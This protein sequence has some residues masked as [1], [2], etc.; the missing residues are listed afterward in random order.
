MLGMTGYKKIHPKKIPH[1]KKQLYTIYPVY[2]LSVC[3]INAKHSMRDFNELYTRLP[4]SRLTS[5]K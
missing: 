1:A 5:G 4:G 3:K 2:I